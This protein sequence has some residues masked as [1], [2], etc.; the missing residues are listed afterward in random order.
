MTWRVC[1]CRFDREWSRIYPVLHN[2]CHLPQ[3]GA[4]MVFSKMKLADTR[5]ITL[6]QY[7]QKLLTINCLQEFVAQF[8]EI[9]FEDFSSKEAVAAPALPAATEPAPPEPALKL[10][11]GYVQEGPDLRGNTSAA[12]KKAYLDKAKFEK[13]HKALLDAIRASKAGGAKGEG[14]S[15]G[16]CHRHR[17]PRCF[18]VLNR[19][20]VFVFVSCCSCPPSLHS[21]HSEAQP[22]FRGCRRVAQYA[23]AS[24]SSVR[25]VAAAGRLRPGLQPRFLAPRFAGFSLVL[26]AACSP[27]QRSR[28]RSR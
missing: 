2:T 3:K 4:L 23:A 24:V 20:F 1:L 19:L 27:R 17:S 13:A 15:N 21:S 22:A 11:R 6:Q 18:F 12:S 5:K 8:L 9:A 16:I 10:Q 26:W 7:I 14:C 28:S 25:A